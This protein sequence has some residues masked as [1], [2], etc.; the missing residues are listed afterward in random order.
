MKI[1]RIF[2]LL[3]GFLILHGR[4]LAGGPGFPGEW[5]TTFGRMALTDGDGGLRGTY[6]AGAGPENTIRG[7]VE[8]RV[9]S[10]DYQEPGATG[11]GSFTLSEDGRTFSGKWREK[12]Q[13]L[14]L[15]WEGRRVAAEASSGFSGV[16]KTSFGLMRLMAAG[17]GVIG[18]Y[19]YGGLS[20][21]TGSVQDGAFR[22][23]YTEPGRTNGSG[24]FRLSADG[25]TFSGTWKTADGGNGGQWQGERVPPVAGRSWLV[26]M[27]AH[28][29]Q[30]LQ[31]PEYSYGDM[32]R[33]FFT[34]VPGVSM[35][36]RFFD[37][38]EDFA[39]WCAELPYLNEPTVFYVSSHGTE[40]GITVGK[41]VLSGEFIGRQLRYA[42][43]VKAV[44]LGA[45]L[46]MAGGVPEALR[47]ACGRPVPVSGFTKVADWAGSAVIDFSYLDLVLSRGIAPGEAVRQVRRSVTFAG[48]E[49]LADVAIRP[50]G[51]KIVE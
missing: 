36:H 11:E 15:P 45:C 13:E 43:E 35:R 24:E 33:Q 18:C 34:R 4:L 27:E 44:H 40:D 49:E 9:F 42:P 10:F 12:G 50:A 46:T 41:H 30:G 51:L 22:F 14:W 37:E 28:W 26:V 1:A 20:E 8:G 39:A 38:E 2:C 16:W 47:K 23:T 6:Q 25:R 19:Q 32:L 3:A 7:K 21:L 5:E 48:E 17:D 29:E 31:E